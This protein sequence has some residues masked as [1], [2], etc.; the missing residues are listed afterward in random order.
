[1]K[2]TVV[3]ILRS[4]EGGIRKHVVDILE[5]I[6]S[7]KFHKIFIT[8]FDDS[9]RDLDYLKIKYQVEFFDLKIK[10]KPE[11]K[12]VINIFKISLFLRRRSN[13]IL[14]GHGAKGGVYARICSLFLR[15][16]CIYTPHGGSLH[17][18]FGKIKSLI[19][20]NI[21]RMLV[22]VTDKFI[23]ESIY[24]ANLF[25]RYIKNCKKKFVINYN[26]VDFPNFYKTIQYKPGRPL[27]LAS[28]GLLRHLKGHD[29]IIDA[30]SVLDKKEVD[31]T[32]SIYGQ[33]EMFD[34]LVQKIEF[35]NLENKVKI[36]NYSDDILAKMCN[37]D[38]IVHPSRFESF[39]Y[40]PVEAMSVK[41]PVICS[42][43][44]GL[45]E[46][47]VSKGT[48]IIKSNSKDEYAQVLYDIYHGEYNLINM[49]EYAYKEAKKK[50]SVHKMIANL[51][52]I[53][54]SL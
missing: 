33:G 44:G 5:N 53:Y 4:P 46:V 50:F 24:S 1:M 37:Y 15:C 30:L 20:D 12:D 54:S 23:F 31:F 29:I 9:D 35:Y 8:S 7:D 48:F 19:Y 13:I 16:P 43:E 25:R 17:R 26:G 39:G 51:S 47:S 21:E 34:T 6:S 2:K 22:P 45:K 36:E 10:D 40:V 14:H 18:S 41:V 27:R 52:S 3:Q 38:F 42:F 32:Y 28:F 49:T 11:F